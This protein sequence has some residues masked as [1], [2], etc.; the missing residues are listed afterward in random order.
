M[1]H[2]TRIPTHSFLFLIICIFFTPTT[3]LAHARWVIDS[4]T[5]PRTN[6][7]GLKVDPCG[8]KPRT[9]RSTI[10]SAGQTIE[11]EFEETVNHPGHY[12]IAF[13][14]ANDLNFDSY[15]LIDNIPDTTNNG[16]YTQQV[17]IPMEVCS[18]CTLQLI[19]VMTTSATP[20]PGDYYYSCTDI[21]ITSPGDTTAPL[22]IASISSQ[23][24]DGQVTV[25][26]SNPTSDF[27]QV[28]VLKSISPITDTPNNGALYSTGDMINSSQVV[29]VGNDN[30]FTAGA[31]TNDL[32]YYFKVF[33][34]N[35]RKNYASGVETNA[36]P[37]ATATGG[38]STG[39]TPGNTGSPDNSGG[40]GSLHLL[41][42]SLFLLVRLTAKRKIFTM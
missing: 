16:A 22:P 7:T 14:P 25:N 6:D 15:V 31:L 20:L 27:Y 23:E 28:V 3:V 8:G 9:T 40:G 1:N 39:N 17:T 5:P 13:S 11:L 21:Q 18:A 2:S 30:T 29:Y 41:F 35:P 24:G 38:G 26:W 36:T 34:Q 4:V 10:F 12:R 32:P 19:Q 42:W 33:A 37:T